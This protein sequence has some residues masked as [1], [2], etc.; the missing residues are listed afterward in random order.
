MSDRWADA[1]FSGALATTAPLTWAQRTMWIAHHRLAPH[2]CALLNVSHTT[3]SPGRR[4]AD[5]LADVAA[6]VAR[7]AVLRST[8]KVD[9]HGAV[10]Q[11]AAASGRARVLLADAS[12]A[13]G[14][15]AARVRA[16][17]SAEPFDLVTAHPVRVALVVDGERVTHVVLVGHHV[18]LDGWSAVRLGLRLAEGPDGAPEDGPVLQPADQA[19][20]EAG[21]E[22]QRLL[23][24]SL[25]Y[26]AEQLRALPP[27]PFPGPPGPGEHPRFKV[28]RLTSPALAT[29]LPALCRRY[30]TTGSTALLA[31]VL[32]LLAVTTGNR[33][34]GLQVAVANRDTPESFDAVG[35]LY[36]EVLVSVD[37]AGARAFSEVVRRAWEASRAGYAHGRYDPPALYALVER[38]NAERGVA[39]DRTSVFNDERISRTARGPA[40]PAVGATTVEWLSEQHRH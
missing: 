20:F 29:A 15:V 11:V 21:P 37:F 4:V 23:R 33:R 18:A 30:R 1:P 9:E 31:G 7:H 19:A 13:G 38:I 22:G 32:A 40:E 17:L 25:A 10:T 35:C 2:D 16:E 12:G 28:A 5:V 3:P 8:L 14:Q 36:Q 6:L 39:L 27:T 24:D 26:W 34:C